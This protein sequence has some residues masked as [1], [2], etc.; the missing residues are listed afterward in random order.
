MANRYYIVDNEGNVCGE[1]DSILKIDLIFSNFS[2]EEV[3]K[4]ELEI[5]EET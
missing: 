4:N 3:E 1:A 5:I 2:K